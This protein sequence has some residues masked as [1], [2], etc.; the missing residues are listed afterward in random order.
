[1]PVHIFKEYSI[2]QYLWCNKVW[3]H[4]VTSG[5]MIFDDLE[6]IPV[7]FDQKFFCFKPSF[8]AREPVRDVTEAVTSLQ[9]LISKLKKDGAK[10][11]IKVNGS[12]NYVGRK[13]EREDYFSYLQDFFWSHQ[14]MFV[15]DSIYPR[16][17]ENPLLSLSLFDQETDNYNQVLPK[18]ASDFFGEQ[19]IIM[20]N[21]LTAS[22]TNF[23]Y[24]PYLINNDNSS[25]Q[26]EIKVPNQI[27]ISGSIVNTL[28]GLKNIFEIRPLTS[29]IS[30]TK[31]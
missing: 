24:D 2:D 11:G 1:M 18:L 14:D 15:N 16:L 30:L 6:K 29:L 28:T 7:E 13:Q 20:T 9:K 21:N 25:L 26:W 31:K 23:I 19:S 3:Q 27:V 17:V 4:L 5:F 8:E 22:L 12:W 10:E